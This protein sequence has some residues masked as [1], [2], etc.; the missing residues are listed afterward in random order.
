MYLLFWLLRKKTIVQ[1]VDTVRIDVCGGGRMTNRKKTRSK[2]KEEKANAF[3]RLCDME[4]SNEVSATA[5]SR[6]H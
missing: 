5:L 3:I 1:S 2:D 4:W 6:L